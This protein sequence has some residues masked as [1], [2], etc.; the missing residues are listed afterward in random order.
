MLEVVEEGLQL[1]LFLHGVRHDGVD[2]VL[3]RDKLQNNWEEPP[4]FNIYLHGFIIWEH[5][6]CR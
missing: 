2:F 3:R 1:L 6:C 5:Q 4:F